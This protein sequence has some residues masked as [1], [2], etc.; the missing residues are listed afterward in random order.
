MITNVRREGLTAWVAGAMLGLVTYTLDAHARR[1]RIELVCWSLS[2][3][4]GHQGSQTAE[5]PRRRGE[6]N[7]E[8][9][10]RRVLRMVIGR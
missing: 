4:C 6:R 2:D 3:G 7:A 1:V 10:A 8:G 5:L 9:S